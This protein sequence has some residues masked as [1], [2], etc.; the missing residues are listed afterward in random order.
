MV[1]AAAGAVEHHAV[2][3]EVERLFGHFTG[4]RAPTPEPARF[5]G[6]SLITL[7]IV[8]SM[9]SRAASIESSFR[10]VARNMMVPG[11]AS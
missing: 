11:S 7:A 3:A 8:C 2:V 5:V 6:G 10:T 1:V 4:P 9:E